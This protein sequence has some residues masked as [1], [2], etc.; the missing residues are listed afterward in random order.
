MGAELSISIM[1]EVDGKEKTIL[2]M[3]SKFSEGGE[4]VLTFEPQQL[5]HL[6]EFKLVVQNAS[7]STEPE[8]D[9]NCK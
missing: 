4:N 9:I 6:K 8:N 5:N 7:E 2:S 3:F 1:G